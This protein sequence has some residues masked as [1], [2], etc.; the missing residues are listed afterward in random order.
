MS[1]QSTS[2]TYASNNLTER[3]Y[4]HLREAIDVVQTKIN[5]VTSGKESEIKA[6]CG[7]IFASAV[8][9]NDTLILVGRLNKL[10]RPTPK[11]PEGVHGAFGVFSGNVEL[12]DAG[13]TT[14]A[15]VV[16]A[17]R[18]ARGELL[19]VVSQ[20][21]IFDIISDP[22]T[23]LL[24]NADWPKNSADTA[25]VLKSFAAVSFLTYV[26]RNE[27]EEMVNT[28]NKKVVGVKQH[29]ITELAVISLNQFKEAQ[30][31]KNA[32]YESKQIELETQRRAPF[33][34]AELKVE[35]ELGK[36]FKKH[37]ALGNGITIASYVARTLFQI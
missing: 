37:V 3:N 18:E 32:E 1:V 28:F 7:L 36:I 4:G 2:E 14:P 5:A 35:P 34:P 10:D 23:R 27:L 30:A 26:P 29:E 21:K 8:D 25:A 20:A 22:K 9:G 19:D 15:V 24:T 16:A 17:D 33:T 12:E 6:S 13:S 31:K 11:D